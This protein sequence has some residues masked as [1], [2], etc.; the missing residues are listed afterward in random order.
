MVGIGGVGMTGLAFLLKESG[1]SVRGSDLKESAYTELLRREGIEVL[2]GHKREQLLPS[3]QLVVYSSAVGKDNPEMQ[4]ALQRAIPTVLRGKLLGEVCA[5]KKTIAVAGSHGKTTT[6]AFIA[7]VLDELGY[8]P[9]FY[10]GGIPLNRNRNAFGGGDY[11]VIETDESDGT[12]LYYQPWVSVITNVDKEHVDH[13]GSEEALR[14]SFSQF[15]AATREKVVGCGDDPVV[16]KILTERG[17]IS[18]GL[19]EEN[20][21]VAKNI[22]LNA[23]GSEFDYYA[24]GKLLCPVKIS[25]LGR[26]N[27]LNS[28]AV[29]CV[30]TLM[31]AP[32]QKVAGIMAAFKGTRR[33]FQVKA[34]VGSVTFVDDYGH[35]PTEIAAT[36]SAARQLKPGRVVVLFQPHR[37]SRVRGLFR[38]FARCFKDAD[39]VFVADI[40]AA[41]EEPIAGIDAS[42]LA[43]AIAKESGVEAV[44]VARD[45]FIAEAAR[46]LKSDDLCLAVG[47][48]DIN[49]MAQG[50]VD[51]FKK[52][53]GIQAAA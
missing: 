5:G 23:D 48:G 7:F 20:Y 27:V 32:A 10:V 40:Y 47:A 26:H 41:S 14:R 22:R 13:Y 25:L 43:Q 11:F 6:S 24:G 53:S 30:A 36:L 52:L 3:A 38:E 34:R 33:R 16:H 42:S 44:Y 45:K 4:E 2:I 39:R 50:V 46:A 9:A 15:A 49:T 17:G 35:H 18:Y 51:E 31:G 29:L 19:G 21:A 37:F 1:F 28:L 8:K 12:F